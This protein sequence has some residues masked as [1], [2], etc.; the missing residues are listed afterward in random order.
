[1]AAGVDRISKEGT[2]TN[3]PDTFKNMLVHIRRENL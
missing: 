1:M 3:L 2:A